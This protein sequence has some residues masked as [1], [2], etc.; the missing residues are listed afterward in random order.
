MYGNRWP[1]IGCACFTCGGG[2]VVSYVE[3]GFRVEGNSTLQSFE[4]LLR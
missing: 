3:G 4:M 1:K 2:A